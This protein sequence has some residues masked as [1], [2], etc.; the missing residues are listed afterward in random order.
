MKKTIRFTVTAAMIAAIYAVLTIA[1]SPIA[2]G[3]MQLRISEAMILFAAITPAAI[4]GLTMANLSSP[5]GLL[6]ILGGASASLLAAVFA[7][8][9]R[10]IRI[11]NIPWL[12]P[13]GAVLFNGLIV[14]MVIKI[15]S[16]SEVLYWAVAG[17][18]ALG[19][20]ASCYL[21]GIPLWLAMEKS[22]LNR[23]LSK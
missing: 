8:L 21:L 20:I 6:D 7:Y 2:F 16:G 10:N 1:I 17:E 9:I 23:R 15:T 22:G 5:Y 3:P 14:G 19:E 12:A 18:I 13:L 4:P 11:K